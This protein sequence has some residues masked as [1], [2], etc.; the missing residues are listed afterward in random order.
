M[1]TNTRKV[2]REASD[3]NTLFLRDQPTQYYTRAVDT[4]SSSTTGESHVTACTST[5]QQYRYVH[6]DW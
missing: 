2:I 3:V 1:K 5:T 6:T 4:S